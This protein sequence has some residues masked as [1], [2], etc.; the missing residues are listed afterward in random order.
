VK[1]TIVKVMLTF[2]F[3]G[4]GVSTFL[5]EMLDTSY[6]IDSATKNSLVIIDELGR[7]TSTFDGFGLAY[8]ISKHLSTVVGCSCLFATHYHEMAQLKVASAKNFHMKAMVDGDDVIMLHQLVPGS[9][10]Q[11]YGI[12]VARSVD[13]PQHVIEAAVEKA[14]KLEN[15]VDKNNYD[16]SV[17]KEGCSMI[18]QFATKIKNTDWNAIDLSERKQTMIDLKN[19]MKNTENKYFRDL[20][21]SRF[22]V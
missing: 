21:F 6:I 15:F 19:A 9:C 1:F 20:V 16:D 3:Q 17:V 7:G 11:S 5:A 8:S 18:K 2:L 12:N 22:K 4:E 13:F 10:E 14:D